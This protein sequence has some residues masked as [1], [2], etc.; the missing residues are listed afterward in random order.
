MSAAPSA[1]QERITLINAYK[2]KVRKHKS[3]DSQYIFT[4]DQLFCID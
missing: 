3:L 1:E 4:L 2:E